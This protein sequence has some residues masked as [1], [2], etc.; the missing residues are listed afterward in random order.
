MKRKLTWRKRHWFDR[1]EEFSP[2]FY[3][4]EPIIT[5]TEVAPRVRWGLPI[6]PWLRREW[7]YATQKGLIHSDTVGI[8]DV[9]WPE[10]AG[11]LPPGFER[12]TKIDVKGTGNIVSGGDLHVGNEKR[13]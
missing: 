3:R 11:V 1:G 10:S 12:Y 7:E 8:R 6:Y 9:V 5:D 4:N 2:R 13:T